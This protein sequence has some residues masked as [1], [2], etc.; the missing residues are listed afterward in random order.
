MSRHR[1]EDPAF[2]REE[3]EAADPLGEQQFAEQG[4]EDAPDGGPAFNAP[5]LEDDAVNKRPGGGGQKVAG[6]PEE[7]QHEM[8]SSDLAR[9]DSEGI[10]VRERGGESKGDPAVGGTRPE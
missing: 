10:V 3:I 5:S 7:R 4:F 6:V 8:N 9:P 2:D 1:N